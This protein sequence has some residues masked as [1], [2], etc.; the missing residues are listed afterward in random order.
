MNDHVA[1]F[2]F[3]IALTFSHAVAMVIGC[4]LTALGSVAKRADEKR[5]SEFDQNVNA[6]CDQKS[7]CET[8]RFSFAKGRV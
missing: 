6:K 5:F 4:F 3:V 8:H 1:A 2:G 7:L